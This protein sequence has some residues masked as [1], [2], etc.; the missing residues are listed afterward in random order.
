MAGPITAGPSTSPTMADI[1]TV[2]H[3]NRICLAGPAAEGPTMTV[4]GF[5]TEGATMV[6]PATAD[7]T[8]AGPT[9]VV[10]TVACPAMEGLVKVGSAMAGPAMADTTTVGPTM[11]DLLQWVRQQ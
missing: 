10:P 7:L 2:C 3:T 6:G 11:A 1:A 4:A 5:A 8:R 9:A